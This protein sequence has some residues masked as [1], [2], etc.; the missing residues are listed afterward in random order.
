MNPISLNLRRVARVVTHLF[1]AEMRRQGIRSTQGSVLFALH[2]T[3]PSNMA[4]LSEVLG[5]E[6]TTLLRNLRP[7]Q[8]DGLVT[9]EGGGQGGHVELSLS[10]KGRKQID[11]LAPAWESAQRTAVQA[12]GEK[13][14]SALLTDLAKVASALKN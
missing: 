14:W 1:D 6:R 11:K 3:G 13:R 9:V 2:A 10:T 12:L 8:R 5:M 7:L 4:E